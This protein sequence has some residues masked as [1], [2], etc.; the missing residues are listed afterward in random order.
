MTDTTEKP[1]L[2]ML[3]QEVKKLATGYPDF[4]Y[5]P[6]HNIEEREDATNTNSGCSNVHGGCGKY[7]D[8]CGCIIGQAV[9]RLG[10]HI[11]E[12]FRFSPVGVLTSQY[13]K[14]IDSLDEHELLQ[15]LQVVQSSQDAG[16]PWSDCV[17][18]ADDRYRM[19]EVF[20]GIPNEPQDE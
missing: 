13:C 15:W 19:L 10:I 14:E 16:L 4:V 20:N 18:E 12:S 9:K 7:P 5:E 6:D 3:I 11:D 8:M 2:A 17:K 1:T